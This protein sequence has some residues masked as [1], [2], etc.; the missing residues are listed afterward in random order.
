[1]KSLAGRR[2]T[3]AAARGAAADAVGRVAG[4]AAVR[5]A[6]NGCAGPRAA[7]R[8][9][10]RGP[11]A[12]AASCVARHAG[13]VTSARRRGGAGRT[14]LDAV[15]GAAGASRGRRTRVPA[16]GSRHTHCLHTRG[17][18]AMLRRL[19]AADAAT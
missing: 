12:V 10:P 18:V 4:V 5:G 3:S 15:R 7:S 8:R 17:V 11:D 16:R 1:M 13:S 19:D 6:E 2:R 14:P 9:P